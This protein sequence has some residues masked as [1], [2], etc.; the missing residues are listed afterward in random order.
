MNEKEIVK[1]FTFKFM[2]VLQEIPQEMFPNDVIIFSCYENTFPVNLIFLLKQERKCSRKE[3]IQQDQ[4]IERNIHEIGANLLNFP[5]L[6]QDNRGM[7]L[8]ER[9]DQ[10]CEF[11]F[12]DLVLETKNKKPKVPIQQEY[13]PLQA[14]LKGNFNV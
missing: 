14:P 2:K 7:N 6:F 3:L 8:E 11:F 13:H 12:P 5:M 1:D 4:V 10:R 9:F